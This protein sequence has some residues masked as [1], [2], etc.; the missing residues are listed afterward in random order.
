MHLKNIAHNLI[1][2]R[3]HRGRF[4]N[5]QKVSQF[6]LN[7]LG[8]SLSRRLERRSGDAAPRRPV[9][10]QRL[11]RKALLAAP[12]NTVYR[13]GHSTVLLKLKG[14]FW[15]TDPVF[16]ERAFPVQWAGPRRFHPP[17]IALQDLP[18]IK[19]VL[20]SHD[21]YDHLDKA[22]IGQ[23]ADTVE[24]FL[25]PL[26]VGDLLQD[27]GVDGGKIQQFDWWQSAT[28]AGVECVATPAQHFSGRGARDSNKRLWCSWTI[29]AGEHRIFFSGDSGYFA[30][31]REIG[32][33][34][35]PFDLTLI[36]TGAYDKNWVD[37]HMLPEQ[38]LQAHLDLRGRCL[39]PIHNGTFDLSIHPWY[40]PFE[41]VY[42]AA[43]RAGVHLATPRMGQAVSLAKP[44]A[45]DFWWRE[46]LEPEPLADFG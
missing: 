9:P 5:H 2:P 44:P 15:L 8:D 12:D 7:M 35:G 25:A 29:L 16:C 10:V 1:R 30:G 24:H 13:L 20:L 43:E 21:H 34:Y 26:G 18:P 46:L 4:A 37:I 32:E 3:I 22:A 11:T 36:E 17:P 14:E 28:V 31:F 33:H 38:S 42:A 6:Q 27:W 23:L 41:R 19:T 45:V 39:L 40:E